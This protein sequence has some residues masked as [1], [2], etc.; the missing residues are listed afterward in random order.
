MLKIWKIRQLFMKRIITVFK[1]LAISKN[2]SVA[3]TNSISAKNIDI[4]HK[5]RKAFIQKNSKQNLNI[6][7]YKNYSNLEVW[8]M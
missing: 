7:R 4:L 8:S 2:I 5:I 3:L 1:L 6:D